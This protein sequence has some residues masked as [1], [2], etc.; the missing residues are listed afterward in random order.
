MNSL[1]HLIIE[2]YCS[3]P[4]F[5]LKKV[6]FKFWP[7]RYIGRVGFQFPNSQT[8]TN[9]ERGTMKIVTY[10]VNGL[11]QRITQFGSLRNLLNS[12]DADIICLQVLCLICCT[13]FPTSLLSL[14][15]FASRIQFG[16]ITGNK[17][18]EAGSDSGLGHGGRIRI[19]LFVH[20]YLWQRPNWVFR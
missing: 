18:E 12:F 13:C 1:R 3:C 8:K 19:I 7:Q 4:Q 2:G 11:R 16:A 14:I 20:P 9:S 5:S 15:F 6:E 17:V 10:N